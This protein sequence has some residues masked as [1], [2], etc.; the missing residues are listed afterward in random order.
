MSIPFSE[1]NLSLQSYYS[2]QSPVMEGPVTNPHQ[3]HHCEQHQSYGRVS[4]QLRACW[5]RPWLYLSPLMT[6]E[7]SGVWSSKATYQQSKI[8]VNRGDNPVDIRLTSSGMISV[9]VSSLSLLVEVYG[10]SSGSDSTSCLCLLYFLQQGRGCESDSSDT[11]SASMIS[12]IHAAIPDLWILHW[13]AFSM[14]GR[15]Q[16]G[17]L[18][19]W[20]V[21]VDAIGISSSLSLYQT[22]SDASFRV[23]SD[24]KAHWSVAVRNTQIRLSW[25]KVVLTLWTTSKHHDMQLEMQKCWQ[26]I[27]TNSRQALKDL[28]QL[29]HCAE[30]NGGWI[31][32][33]WKQ[34]DLLK[35]LIDIVGSHHWWDNYQGSIWVWAIQPSKTADSEL[36]HR[37]RGLP[38]THDEYGEMLGPTDCPHSPLRCECPVWSMALVMH[39]RPQNMVIPEEIWAVQLSCITPWSTNIVNWSKLDLPMKM[40]YVDA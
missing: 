39:E 22:M 37:N 6:F 20:T 13:G 25:M 7:T 14:Q 27:F 40:T 5:M 34:L 23:P 38:G 1:M 32:L 35:I 19:V 33:Q 36:T 17:N 10:M 29:R 18:P 15:E 31:I 21:L 28:G 24:C 8:C 4:S 3:E 11:C 30:L 16:R 12:H 26:T 9:I 2:K